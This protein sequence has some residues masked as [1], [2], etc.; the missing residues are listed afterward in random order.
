MEE[1]KKKEFTKVKRVVIY[2]DGEPAQDL[3]LEE[4]KPEKTESSEKIEEEIVKE[5]IEKKKEGIK[6]F[7]GDEEDFKSYL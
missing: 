2:Y 1:E 7:I 3:R 5:D 4:E 6:K